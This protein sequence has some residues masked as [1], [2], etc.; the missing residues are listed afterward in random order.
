MEEVD[1]VESRLG[2]RIKEVKEDLK[3]EIQV[4]KKDLHDR[5]TRLETRLQWSMGIAVAVIA[6]IVPVLVK[7]LSS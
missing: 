2:D 6:I 3:G 5:I 7:F 1:K 4:V